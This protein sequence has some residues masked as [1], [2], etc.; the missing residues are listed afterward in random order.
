MERFRLLY[1]T[2]NGFISTAASIRT[3]STRT[4]S[5]RQSHVL[6]TLVWYCIYV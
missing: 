5:E 6:T 3:A 2:L 4:N 1:L